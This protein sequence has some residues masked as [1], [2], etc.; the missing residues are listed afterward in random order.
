MMQVSSYNIS[1][2][3]AFELVGRG[4]VNESLGN[5]YCLAAPG[6]KIKDPKILAFFG[7]MHGAVVMLFASS[8]TLPSKIMTDVGDKSDLQ[9]IHKGHTDW[10]KNADC[11]L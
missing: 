8:M 4:A 3:N 5:P 7:D 9:V 11:L 6:L 1:R 2:G 10:V